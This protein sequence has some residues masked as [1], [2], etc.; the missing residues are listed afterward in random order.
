MQGGLDLAA[1]GIAAVS[2]PGQGGIG[3]GPERIPVRGGG[4]SYLLT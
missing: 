4:G 2:K 1:V 3:H